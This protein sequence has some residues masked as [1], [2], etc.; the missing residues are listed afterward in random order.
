[1]QVTRMM[2]KASAATA[3]GVQAKPCCALPTSAGK[4]SAPR[5]QVV[6]QALPG[7]QPAARTHHPAPPQAAAVAAPP[8]KNPANLNDRQ[9]AITQHFPQVG[10][11]VCAPARS[12]SPSAFDDAR[13]VG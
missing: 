1:M 2:D 7:S 13:V 12:S 11:G 8:A 9:T 6:V 3:A 5:Q 10:A 4:R